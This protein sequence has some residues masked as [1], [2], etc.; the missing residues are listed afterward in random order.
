MTEKSQVVYRL[1]DS[2]DIV[3]IRSASLVS[4]FDDKGGVS[5][6]KDLGGLQKATVVLGVAS[7]PFFSDVVGDD[8]VSQEVFLR[9]MNKE[10]RRVPVADLD[11]VFRDIQEF[12]KADFG[13]GDVEKK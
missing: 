6:I 4:T 11:G 7:A 5:T 1:F 9:R 8:G 3:R 13:L 10:F 12:N 2:D